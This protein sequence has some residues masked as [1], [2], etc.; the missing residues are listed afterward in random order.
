M[1]TCRDITVGLVSG[2]GKDLQEHRVKVHAEK[3]VTAYVQG[4][5][6]EVSLLRVSFEY[7]LT[8]HLSRNFFTST[9]MIY[10]QPLPYNRP[11]MDTNWRWYIVRQA[12][13]VM[14]EASAFPKL[15]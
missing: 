11:S 3:I 14:T 12:K 5:E 10:Q 6:G 4:D 9:V 1:P 13:R 15:S 2:A 7:F 8:I